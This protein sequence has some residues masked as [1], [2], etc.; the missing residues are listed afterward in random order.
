MRKKLSNKSKK[1]FIPNLL[2]SP[3]SIPVFGIALILNTYLERDI[4][5]IRNIQDLS[6]FQRFLI[7]IA[8]RAGQLFNL[9]EIGK[10]CSLKQ[11]QEIG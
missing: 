6:V 10:E 2:F 5:S 1:G 9:L 7:L 8:A 4:G 3:I 11:P